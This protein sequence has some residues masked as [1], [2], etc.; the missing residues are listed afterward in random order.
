MRT[1]K[2]VSVVCA[3]V[4]GER[5]AGPSIHA[6]QLSRALAARFD[7][8]LLT[9]SDGTFGVGERFRLY[10]GTPAA[11]AD[12]GDASDVIIVQGDVLR[13]WPILRRSKAA[14]IADNTVTCATAAKL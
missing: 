14:L 9:R 10:S 13:R 12:V 7:V 8:S 2:R 11:A 1:R 3:D 5:M 6:V 4:V